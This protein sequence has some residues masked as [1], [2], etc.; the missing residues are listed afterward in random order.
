MDELIL[1]PSKIKWMAVFII[2]S[3]FV[4]IGY[5][6]TQDPDNF[7]IGWTCILFF[8]L[9]IVVTPAQLLPKSAYLHL[10]DTGFKTKGVFRKFFLKWK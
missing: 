5:F 9:G 8:G 2:S 1:R 7:M 10:T 6:I 3:V 4:I